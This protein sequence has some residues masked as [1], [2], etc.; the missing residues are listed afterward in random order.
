MTSGEK[1]V[2]TDYQPQ[3]LSNTARNETPKPM[4]ANISYDKQMI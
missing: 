1:K 3:N 4:K 2:I